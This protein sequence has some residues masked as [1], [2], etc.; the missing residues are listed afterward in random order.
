[1][2]L[3]KNEYNFIGRTFVN[4]FIFVFAL[5]ALYFLSIYNISNEPYVV[6]STI[7]R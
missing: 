3:E 5:F 6:L 2:L 4:M 7:P 1:M